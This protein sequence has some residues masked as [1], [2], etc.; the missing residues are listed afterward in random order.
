MT[1]STYGKTQSSKNRLL[2]DCNHWTGEGSIIILQTGATLHFDMNKTLEK[3]KND[4]YL[5][6]QEINI[7]EISETWK[8]EF[9]FFEFVDGQFKVKLT[10]DSVGSLYGDGYF[11]DTDIS[12][13]IY[14]EKERIIG[15]TQFFHTASEIYLIN[16]TYQFPGTTQISISGIIRSS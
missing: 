16:S 7:R 8:T 13:K 4:T 10:N 15:K 14:D 11:N 6:S 1:Q 12:W 9:E 3:R 2:F 5:M